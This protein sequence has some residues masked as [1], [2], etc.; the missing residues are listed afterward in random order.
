MLQLVGVTV[1]LLLGI[2]ANPETAKPGVFQLHDGERVVFLGNTLIERAAQY[3]YIET[4]LTRMQPGANIT[5]RNLGWSG[6]TVWGE[7]RAGFETPV[8]GFERLKESVKVAQPTLIFVG[9]G[10]NEAFA[11]GAGLPKFVIG[12]QRLLDA[13]SETK[14]RIVLLSPIRHEDLGRPLPDPAPH[15]R[16]L[17]VYANAM[18][19]IAQKRGFGWIELEPALSLRVVAQPSMPLTENG[20][21]LNAYGYWRAAEVIAQSTRENQS[22]WRVTF[23]AD[24]N[25]AE[26]SGTRI[27]EISRAD[28]VI[29]WVALDEALPPLSNPHASSH[30]P[31]P[32][33]PQRVLKVTGLDP[34]N[35]QLSIDGQPCCTATAEQWNE[36]VAITTGPEYD[37][38]EQL[39]QAILHKNR[40]FFYRWRPQNTTY[41]FGF[42]KHEQGN[43]AAEVALFDPLVAESEE[44]IARLRRP[45]EHTYELTKQREESR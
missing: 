13:L 23:A 16:H 15:N 32:V 41:L 22:N 11:G 43:N 3:G 45:V 37:A 30:S 4:Q 19:Q 38:T 5:F 35:Y 42:R 8:E 27:R 24:G 44:Q 20:M 9:Y 12:L 7:S 10:G 31:A 39:R 33:A 17:R 2:A 18:R 28:D 25:T 29:K 1:S 14:A 26:T 21:H 36:G 40:L 34:G 6:D